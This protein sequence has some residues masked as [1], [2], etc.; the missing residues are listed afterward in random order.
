MNDFTNNLG[1]SN[2]WTTTTKYYQ[3]RWFTPK[4]HATSK[5]TIAKTVDDNYSLGKQ[6]SGTSIQTI[7]QAKVSA[8]AFPI[9]QH[10]VY[11]VVTSAD[12]SERYDATANYCDDYCGYHDLQTLTTTTQGITVPIIFVGVLELTRVRNN[13]RD[14][15]VHRQHS[16]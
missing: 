10:G 4:E 7:I 12:V 9:D 11:M 8:N 5:I 15:V 3:H 6:L 13:A 2:W 14:G 1:D 16:Q